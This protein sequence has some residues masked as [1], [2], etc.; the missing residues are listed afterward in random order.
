MGAAILLGRIHAPGRMAVNPLRDT[1][2]Q[3]SSLTQPAFD[4]LLAS[5]GPDRDA[6]AARYLEIRRNLVRLFEWRGC[7]TPEE[8]A[9]ETINR[10][11]RKVGDGEVIR[12]VA[13]YCI[14]IAR[15]L[16]L[17]MGRDRARQPRPLD[18]A[19]E[20]QVVPPEPEDDRDRRV[21]C[22]RS[23]LGQLP[24]D[25]RTLILRYYQG[26][27]GDKIKNR[28]GLTRTL[29]ISPGTLRMRALRLRASLQ[30]CAENCL[31][32]QDAQSR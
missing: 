7:S 29:G 22:L 5:L 1:A 28:N 14:G 23:C 21:E 13:T 12:D 31:Q 4:G 11:A 26:D 30:L 8:Y 2:P 24:A 10:C 18:E 25:H 15:M 19:P 9:D 6:A 32:S 16:L 3:V 17:E 27:K 20:P